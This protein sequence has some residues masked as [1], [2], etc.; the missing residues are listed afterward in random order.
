MSQQ[1][2]TAGRGEDYAA[3]A[4]LMTGWIHRDLG[5]WDELAALF[6]PGATIDISW[7]RGPVEDFIEG[8]RRMSAGP[9]S[10]KHLVASP[11]VDFHGDRAFVETN[12]VIYMTHADLHL[13]VEQHSRFLDRVEQIDGRWGIVHRDASYD[14]GW[15][16]Y[17][18]GIELA[19]PV[20]PELLEGL[21]PEYAPMAYLNVRMGHPL[22][23]PC[24]TRG[25][26]LEAAIR[27]RGAEWLAAG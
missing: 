19:D 3:I 11:V 18:F 6:H 4:R 21:A 13:G 8:S 14:M 17:P 23:R 7:V 16:T 12:A 10:S 15:F 1:A 27:A 20:R 5:H 2:S 22:E 9:I 25:S 24:A 26:A